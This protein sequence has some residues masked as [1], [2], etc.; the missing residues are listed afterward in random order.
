MPKTPVGLSDEKAARM[1]VA[2]RGGGTLNKFGVKAPRLEAYFNAH[3]E[4]ALEARPLI[5]A[6]AKAA[7]L[8]KGARLRN[9]THCKHGHSLANARF[10]Y[11]RTDGYLKRDCRTCGQIRHKRAGFITPQGIIEVKKALQNG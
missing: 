3:P 6:N 11:Q 4:Y 9:Q 10:F 7:L 2:L 1:M 5:E 8:R